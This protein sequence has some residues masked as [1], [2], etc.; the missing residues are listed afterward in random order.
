M[1][2][3]GENL[4]GVM[5]TVGGKRGGCRS[6]LP[7]YYATNTTAISRLH[8]QLQAH[9]RLSLT[10]STGFDRSSDSVRFLFNRRVTQRHRVSRIFDGMGTILPFREFLKIFRLFDRRK[11][12]MNRWISSNIRL[13]Y[14]NGQ[15][16]KIYS[17]NKV[18]HRRNIFGTRIFYL[19]LEFLAHESF[20]KL[21]NDDF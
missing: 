9:A 13:L 18:K 6:R 12:E 10:I 7:A 20:L 19:P 2:R 21:L 15:Q 16:A 14:L 11:I 3:E 1:K 4:K 5:R 17:R 8:V